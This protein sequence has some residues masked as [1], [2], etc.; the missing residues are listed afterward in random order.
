MKL[1]ASAISQLTLPPN[2]D[3][4]IFFDDELPGFGLRLR[5]SGDRSWWVQYGIAGRTRKM[6]LGSVA[7]LDISKARSTAKTI[8]AQ[9]RLG[10]DP[11][12]EKSHARV[13]A[14][15]TVGV[16]LKPF[17][18]RQ[19]TRL[20]PRSIKATEWHLLKL[21]R[22][23]HGMPIAALTRR[24]I[25]ARLAEIAA[26]NGPAAANRVRGSLG[27]FCGWAVKE[28]FRDD[29]PVAF[30]NKAEENGPRD[31]LLSDAELA[32]IWQVLGDGQYSVIVKLLILTG[33]RRGEVGGLRW[34]EIDLG[35]NLIIL[36]AERTKNGRPHLVPLSSVVRDLI[37]A[38]PRRDDRDGR[39]RDRLF[40]DVAVEGF[41]CWN[42]AKAELEQRLA[43]I[44]GE[45]LAPWALH[46]IRRSF[47][48]AL[49]DRF[50]VPPHIVEVLLGHVG[51][52][53]GVAGTYNK[54]IYLAECERAL[55]RWADHVT[56]IA[57]NRVYGDRVVPLRA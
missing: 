53:S 50:G 9:V 54:S 22:P 19:Q 3:D 52:Q 44:R 46:D 12:S 57:E 13:R 33:L 24:T 11:A 56:A 30:T 40:G 29:N 18:L 45:P 25:A 14:G 15:E 37:E 39:P 48:T 4:K 23:L 51:H 26:A 31:R 35:S 36:P 42:G 49:H 20:R 8:L 21:C 41:S 17:L 27:A 1:T 5:R 34:S 32:L 28:G 10:G 6:R 7:E 16:L 55:S 43:E 47:S 38:Q 2:I